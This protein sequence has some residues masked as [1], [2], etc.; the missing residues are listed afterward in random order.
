[1]CF[2]RNSSWAKQKRLQRRSCAGYLREAYEEPDL[3]DDEDDDELE[4][5]L[6]PQLAK[7]ASPAASNTIVCVASGCEAMRRYPFRRKDK[8]SAKKAVLFLPSAKGG[9]FAN[10]KQALKHSAASKNLD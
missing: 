6:Q 3:P 5:D 1:M 10:P 7:G 4:D 8:P 9:F 2:R